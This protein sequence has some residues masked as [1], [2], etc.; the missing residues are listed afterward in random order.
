M[1]C[2]PAVLFSGAILPVPEMAVVGR[3]ISMVMPDRWAF[4]AIGH[5]LGLRELFDS[6]PSPLG[7]ALLA[8]FGSTW[9]TS[10]A[11]T[12][13][14]LVGFAVAFL[15]AATSVLNRRCSSHRS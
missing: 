1:L 15:A 3:A 8:D 10:A 12:W 11:Q 4:E 6:D 7:S 2:F 13:L 5:D 9:T 14:I